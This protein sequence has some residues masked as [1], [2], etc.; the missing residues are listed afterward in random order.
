MSIVERKREIGADSAR[1]EVKLWSGC[2]GGGGKFIWYYEGG[3]SEFVLFRKDR[4]V[5]AVVTAPAVVMV[6]SKNRL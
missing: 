2:H 1:L 6:V 4:V 3:G 5:G